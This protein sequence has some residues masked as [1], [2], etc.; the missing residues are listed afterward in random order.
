MN[1]AKNNYYDFNL[2]LLTLGKHNNGKNREQLT[3]W[4]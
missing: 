4:K 2:V 1:V 3:V